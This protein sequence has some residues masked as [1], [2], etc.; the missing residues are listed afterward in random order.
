MVHALNTALS[1]RAAQ[2]GLREE[3]AVQAAQAAQVCGAEDEARDMPRTLDDLPAL[4]HYATR[5]EHAGWGG[6]RYLNVTT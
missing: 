4:S 6:A 3:E 1:S 2:G 5:G